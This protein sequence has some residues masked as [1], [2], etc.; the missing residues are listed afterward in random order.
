LRRQPS[1]FCNR[2]SISF[3]LNKRSSL[4]QTTLAM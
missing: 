1:T 2:N 4:L 3:F